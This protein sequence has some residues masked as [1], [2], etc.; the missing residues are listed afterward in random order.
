MVPFDGPKMQFENRA[1]KEES[2]KNWFIELPHLGTGQVNN[3]LK[4]Y[5]RLISTALFLDPDANFIKLQLKS[6]PGDQMT[7]S[8]HRADTARGVTAR[9]QSLAELSGP[10]IISRVGFLFFSVVDLAMVGHYA[11]QSLGALS[12]AH[13]IID[14]FMLFCAGALYGVIV[15]CSMSVGDNKPEEAGAH[16]KRGAIYAAGVGLIASLA[17]WGFS[18]SLSWF[19]FDDAFGAE[20]RLLMLLLIPGLVP[21][22]VHIAYS[23][24]LE[25][26]SN[27]V[28]ATIVVLLANVLN[29]FLNYALVFGQFGAP[30]MG[31]EGSAISTT[32][33]RFVLAIGLIAFV[34]FIYAKRGLYHVNK[35]FTWAW[36]SWSMMRQIGISGGVSFGLE[37]GSYMALAL[38]AGLLSPMAAATMAVLI[39]IRSLLFM[40][41]MGI[42]FATSVQVGMGHG[43]GDAEE[44]NQSTWVGMGFSVAATFALCIVIWVAPLQIIGIYTE[45]DVLI[46]AASL[47]L[48]LLAL[49]MVLD[50]GQATMASALRGREDAIVPMI[51]H[52]IAFIVVMQPVAWALG[53]WNG[54]GALG[55]FQAIV[56]GNLCAAAL[57]TLRHFQ[58]NARKDALAPDKDEVLTENS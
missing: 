26:V 3:Y 31:A 38:M 45:D 23:F 39:N 17:A 36:S 30:E 6:F 27:P 52:A 44:V 32:I 7:G 41:P 8:E 24:F 54:S 29:L 49:A 34:H 13:A 19:G 35:A 10:I 12:I 14:T 58:L 25:G 5:L 9:I 18:Y 40:V 20:V 15:C 33:V 2:R 47:A 28:P 51:I 16:L 4:F 55:L 42:S 56:L 50:A 48:P 21:V 43:A 37:A 46:G 57:L 11:T 53:I 1:V 22:L